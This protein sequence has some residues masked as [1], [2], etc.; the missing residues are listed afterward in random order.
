[1]VLAESSSPVVLFE[2]G[3]PARYYMNP[4]D[5][6]FEHLEPS[7]TRSECPYKGRT[8]GYWSVSVNGKVHS[9]LA[10]RT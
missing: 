2:T 8:T 5:I 7:Q 3:L 10:A 1:M 4:F 9:D 6:R